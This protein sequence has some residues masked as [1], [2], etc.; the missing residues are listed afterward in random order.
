MMMMMIKQCGGG[1][2]LEAQ[3]PR[4]DSMQLRVYYIGLMVEGGL[5]TNVEGE[6]VSN[7]D[8]DDDD[9]AMWRRNRVVGGSVTQRRLN[10][11]AGLLA[12]DHATAPSNVTTSENFENFE[13]WKDLGS[14]DIALIEPNS[15]V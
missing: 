7:D 14:R 2:E 13:V 9:K 11:V 12:S 8:D 5:V 15:T 1:T 6:D 3:V 10:V 4:G